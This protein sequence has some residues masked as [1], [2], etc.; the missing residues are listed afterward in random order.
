M[1]EVSYAFQGNNCL[2]K[3]E[4]EN[5]NKVNFIEKK[6]LVDHLIII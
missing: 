4:S 5:M 1:E 2:H 3:N 6:G